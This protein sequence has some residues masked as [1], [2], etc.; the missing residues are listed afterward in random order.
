MNK[1]ET[2]ERDI[3]ED[4]VHAPHHITSTVILAMTCDFYPAAGQAVL[5]FIL[6]HSQ[7]CKLVINYNKQTATSKT[8]K[9]AVCRQAT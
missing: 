2:P 1:N 3:N 7:V 5:V 6:E 9:E 8:E 4:M